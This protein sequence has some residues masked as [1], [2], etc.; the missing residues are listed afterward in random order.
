MLKAAQNG[1]WAPPSIGGLRLAL[2]HDY[3]LVLRGAERTFATIAACWPQAPIFTL[4]YDEEGTGSAFA[5]RDIRSS[6]LQRLRSTQTEFRRLLPLFPGAVERLPIGGYDLV[7]SSSSAFAH[8]VRPGPDAIHVCYCHSPFRYVWHE[9]NRAVTEVRRRLRPGFDRWLDR[10]Q[11]WDRRA[12]HRVDHFIANSE[13]TRRRIQD[14][15]GRDAHV[16]HP[17]VEVER[18]HVG[19]PEDYLLVVGEVVSHKRLEVAL[20][21]ARRADRHVKVVGAGPLLQRMQ[22]RFEAVEFLG[23]VRDRDLADLYAGALALVVPNVEEFGIA[24]VEAQAAGRP[25]LA[26]DAGGTGETVIPGQTGVLLDRGTVDEF[27]E[28]MRHVDFTGFDSKLIRRYS[29]RFSSDRFRARLVEE[30]TRLT[31]ARSGVAP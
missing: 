24:A 27:A 19:E 30:I 6:Y 22:R 11:R 20:E 4:L 16:I 21:A 1:R 13:L 15:W 25:V 18:L 28:A 10:V 5:D 2:V 23:R 12:A 7:I 14:Y 31:S 29:Q 8:G 9:R 17:P 3:L 26:I